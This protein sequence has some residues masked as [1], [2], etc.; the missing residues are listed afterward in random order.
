MNTTKLRGFILFILLCGL[1]GIGSLLV[2]VSAHEDFRV[3]EVFLKADD[4]NLTGKC[5]LPVKFNGYI[6]ANGTGTVKYTFTRSDGATSPVY[7]LY[8]KEA[9][10]QA[11][12]SDWTLGDATALPRYEGWQAIKI[13]SPNEM[14]SSHETGSFA[15]SCIGA[16]AT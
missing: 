12:A 5:P 15:L 2:K 8:F 11:V 4:G 13:L 1:I 16:P 6:T 10:T 14:E 7:A 3:T 9:G